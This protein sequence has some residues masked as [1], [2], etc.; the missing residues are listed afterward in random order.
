VLH[1][2]SPHRRLLERLTC[3]PRRLRW[4]RQNGV[5]RFPSSLARWR[6]SR[7]RRSPSSVG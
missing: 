4:L 2:S 1:R 3:P 7:R 6:S 5:R